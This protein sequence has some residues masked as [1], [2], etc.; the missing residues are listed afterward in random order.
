[1]KVAPYWD[2]MWINA[3]SRDDPDTVLEARTQLYTS[4]ASPSVTAS[5][6]LNGEDGLIDFGD[7]FIRDSLDI[8]F[9]EPPLR[10]DQGLG[11]RSTGRRRRPARSISPSSCSPPSPGGRQRQWLMP[12][13]ADRRRADAGLSG[14][15]MTASAAAGPSAIGSVVRTDGFVVPQ[16]YH[17]VVMT[18]GTGQFP[19]WTMKPVFTSPPMTF[20]ATGRRR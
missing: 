11:R 2:P 19:I 10:R 20:R 4:T 8:A 13:V 14:R 1:M 9:G 17:Q 16:D 6:I 15:R 7:D 5:D 18:N 3:D 12:S